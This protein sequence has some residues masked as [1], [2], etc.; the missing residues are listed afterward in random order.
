MDNDREED[1]SSRSVELIKEIL[2]NNPYIRVISIT[3][4]TT[5][6]ITSAYPAKAI[7]LSGICDAPLFSALEP[8]I[9]GALAKCIRVMLLVESDN[10]PRHI[11]MRG[12]KV[13]R[14]D[15]ANKAPKGKTI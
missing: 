10:A 9:K 1:I 11:Y 8:P 7:R 6:D 4:S 15:Y 2:E 13:L 3:I 14:P 12:A 5:E